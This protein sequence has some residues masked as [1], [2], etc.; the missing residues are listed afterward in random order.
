M[1]GLSYQ[2]H[3][4]AGSTVEGSKTDSTSEVPNSPGTSRGSVVSNS[5]P[6]NCEFNYFAWIDSLRINPTLYSTR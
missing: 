3:S 2:S 6:R 5:C 1:T 4:Q